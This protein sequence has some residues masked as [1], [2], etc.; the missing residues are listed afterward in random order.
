MYDLKNKMAGKFPTMF[1]WQ[2]KYALFK[3][4]VSCKCSVGAVA[5]VSQVV[6]LSG[7]F[8]MCIICT[9]IHIKILITTIYLFRYK[10]CSFYTWGTSYWC[11]LSSVNCVGCILFSIHTCNMLLH[12]CCFSGICEFDSLLA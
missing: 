6:F 8:Y 11:I 9:S 4:E 5:H 2:K 1:L 3:V 10:T 12:C 7:Q